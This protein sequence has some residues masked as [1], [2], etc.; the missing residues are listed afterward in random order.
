VVDSII[1]QTINNNVHLENYV[2]QINNMDNCKRRKEKNI[3]IQNVV[4]QKDEKD[5]L[6]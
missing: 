6:D 4:L 1:Q 2:I 3:G 5:K